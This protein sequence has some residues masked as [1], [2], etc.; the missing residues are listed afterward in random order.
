MAERLRQLGVAKRLSEVEYGNPLRRE[1]RGEFDH[2]AFLESG[3]ALIVDLSGMAQ[4]AVR[5]FYLWLVI[6]SIQEAMK[7]RFALLVIG[8]EAN[9]GLSQSALL[10]D[11]AEQCRKARIGVTLC[12]Q[13][14]A[15]TP[16]L[17]S[18][19]FQAFNRIEL[20]QSSPDV[21]K[22]MLHFLWPLV[23]FHR[24]H[25]T[26]YSWR[27]Y[28]DGYDEVPRHRM[29][30]T[31]SELRNGGSEPSTSKSES[32]TDSWDSVLL[33]KRKLVAE[34]R[35]HY[36]QTSDQLIDS[37][38]EVMQQGAGECLVLQNGRAHWWTVPEPAPVFPRG[39][40]NYYE[41]RFQEFLAEMRSRPCFRTPQA[42][43]LAAQEGAVCRLN[44]VKAAAKSSTAG[45]IEDAPRTLE[46]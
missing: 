37:A 23:D 25:H 14:I 24:V 1:R 13:G 10:L 44:R 41:R 5:P 11:L 32:W 7:R 46:S 20:Y 45:L 26:E 39:L 40:E 31:K 2:I 35:E 22:D 19:W 9:R 33:A 3:G 8:D 18:R 34:Q 16:E 38:V 43:T 27:E 36:W 28:S 15:F 21:L 12:K 30:R 42:R 4:E 6:S 17:R 29:S